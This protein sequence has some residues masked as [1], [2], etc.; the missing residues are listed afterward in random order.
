MPR[1]AARTS[2]VEL[3]FGTL[4]C[5][6]VPQ[7]CLGGPNAEGIVVELKNSLRSMTP[8]AVRP[9]P[10]RFDNKLTEKVAVERALEVIEKG[11]PYRK[12]L[13]P[14]IRKKNA[15]SPA[16]LNNVASRSPGDSPSSFERDG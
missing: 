4:Q 3:E 11:S 14:L 1:T 13:P 9:L 12:D 15:C 7:H 10:T 2:F 8:L 5:G 6:E 16:V